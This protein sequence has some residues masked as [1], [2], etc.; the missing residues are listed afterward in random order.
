MGRMGAHARMRPVLRPRREPRRRRV[1]RDV[2]GRVHEMILVER[3]LA[4]PALKQ[5]AGL[6]RAG[7]D[8]AGIEAAPPR[9]RLLN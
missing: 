5:M 7:V 4:E 9:E 1:Q 2:A 6:A 8:E 3:D